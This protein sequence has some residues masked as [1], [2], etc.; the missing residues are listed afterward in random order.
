MDTSF[1]PQMD[2]TLFLGEFT[3]LTVVDPVPLAPPMVG[4]LIIDPS[5][6]F[7]IEVEWKLKG[8]FVPVWLSALSGSNWLVEAYADAIGPGD[9]IR[10]ADTTVA[11]GVVS[12]PKIYTAKLT[13][14]KNTLK[15]HDPGPSGPSGIYRL[16]VS[17]F[18]NSTLGPPGY[19]ITGF[20]E[21]VTIRAEIPV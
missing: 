6:D 16:T 1:D 20:A 15:E 2:P 19:D 5:K 7:T 3:K 4:N 13:V 21:G 9:E 18:L 14:K 17:A 12:D 11:V 8:F 10:I